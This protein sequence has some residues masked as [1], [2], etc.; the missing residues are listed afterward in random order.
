MRKL[1]SRDDGKRIFLAGK[2]S[3]EQLRAVKAA[4]LCGL[5]LSSLTV[6]L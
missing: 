6:H 1:Y 2:V 3:D 5:G 4:M